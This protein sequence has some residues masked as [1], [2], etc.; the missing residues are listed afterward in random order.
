MV[1]IDIQCDKCGLTIEIDKYKWEQKKK[2]CPECSGQFKRVW[3]AP[4]V[5]FKGSGFYKNDSK[6]IER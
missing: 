1:L 5:S 6:R 2:S 3:A 4:G